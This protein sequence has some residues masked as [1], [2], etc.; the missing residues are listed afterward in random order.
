M[1]GNICQQC[2]SACAIN[3]GLKKDLKKYLRFVVTG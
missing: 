3:A 2:N 1:R